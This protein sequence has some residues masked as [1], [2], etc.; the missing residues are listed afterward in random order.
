M[1]LLSLNPDGQHI[2]NRA[3]GCQGGVEDYEEGEERA[4]AP[5]VL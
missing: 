1:L 5:S 2:N 4:E 3:A